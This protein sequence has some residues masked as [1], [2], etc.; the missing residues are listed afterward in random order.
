MKKN[1]G[2]ERITVSGKAAKRAKLRRGPLAGILL[3]AALFVLNSIVAAGVLSPRKYRVVQGEPAEETITASHAVE[4]TAATE[5]LRH[6]AR[7]SVSPV[8]TLDRELAE[9]LI[10]Q[11]A[12]FFDAVL[13]MRSDA[14][15]AREESAAEND[16]GEEDART[17]REVVD[18]AAMASMLLRLPIRVTDPA[19]GY[20][21][22]EASAETIDTLRETVESGLAEALRTGI[23]EET[24][25]ATR[26]SLSRTLQI[27]TLPTNLKSVGEIVYDVCLQPTYIPD[28]EATE[29]AR[30]QAANAV[31]S[32]RI[33][34]GTE[35][36]K[37]GETVTE[38]HMEILTALGAVR[39]VD[40]NPLFL[41]G[42]I[43]L[44][45]AAYAVFLAMLRLFDKATFTS[46]KRML[47]LALM[48]G[49]AVLLEWVCY[50]MDP[51]V[52]PAMLPVLLCTVLIGKEAA[53]CVNFLAAVVFGFLAGGSGTSM[54]QA[55]ALTA[56]LAQLLS[57]QAAIALASRND[58]RS[59][60]VAAGALGGAVAAAV[61][62]AAAAMRG[63]HWTDALISGGIAA[64]A[65]LV[66]SLLCVGMLSLWENL[67]DVATPAR[68][69]ELQSGN[70][71]L[72]KRLM[73]NTPGTY[74]HA[75]FTA[76]L[77]EAAAEQIGASALLARAGGMYH[78]VGKLKK[79]QYF[80]ENQTNRNIH[81]T[82]SPE[83]SAAA[84]I[85]HQ[86]DAEQLLQR[87]RVP[88]AVRAIARE[89]H[90]TTLVAYF[91]HNAKKLY[92]DANVKES[93]YRYPGPKPSTRESAIVMLADSCEAAVRSLADPSP[94]EV[95]EMVHKVFRGKLED[96]QFAQCPITLQELDRVERSFLV[97]FG[98]LMHERIRY[99]E[100]ADGSETEE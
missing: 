16:I 83:K 11:S 58:R 2:K 20:A 34:R 10:R 40:D 4:D 49:L 86:R 43:G 70:H 84:I 63:L 60:I 27:T 72:L 66:L 7:S 37:K 92:G 78:D 79:P 99:P 98:G 80:K 71:P 53:L 17:W 14:Q 35:I 46:F 54:L 88:S 32:V 1:G 77:A 50:L 85:A 93:D 38:A 25:E 100:D 24:L 75:M 29:R 90:G 36:V 76:A 39:G 3:I 45:L 89:H 41:V 68:L 18:S 57:G 23:T 73:T 69:H 74:Q 42:V 21:L 15:T 6:I 55:D 5:A 61:A 30:E 19:L 13:V 81:D 12:D 65:P 96:G 52:S 8:Y 91:Y 82:L 22:L 26:T 59:S 62:L 33:A 95:A 48:L 44:L 51:R 28:A 9:S 67:F 87:Y 31:A 56:V 94:Q 64:A 47:M 97:T